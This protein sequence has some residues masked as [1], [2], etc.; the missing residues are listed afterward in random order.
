MSA[1]DLSLD[2]LDAFKAGALAAYD[3]LIANLRRFEDEDLR[4]PTLLPG[5]S[6]GHLATHIARN[7]DSHVRLLDAALAGETVEQYAGGWEGRAAQ[8]NQGATRSAPDLVADVQSSSHALF[9]YWGSAPDHLWSETVHT[10]SGSRPAWRLV[11]SR[12][13]ELD[14]HHVDLDADYAPSDWS[15]AFVDTLLGE[16]A[17]T[18]PERLPRGASV[19]FESL[20][21]RSVGQRDPFVFRLVAE[22][23]TQGN[24]KAGG[25]DPIVVGG[26]KPALLAWLI[27]R[28]T[29]A[30]GLTVSQAG[31]SVKLPELRP[32]A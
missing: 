29:V 4:R 15:D 30:K 22:S 16:V 18:L 19:R 3:P 31:Q 7:A 1:L 20:D 21:D 25:A 14:I 11:W 5:W 2:N 8:I 27:G 23:A 12:W 6:R 9:D 28:P 32:W 24:M 26:A 17:E 13:R 10:S